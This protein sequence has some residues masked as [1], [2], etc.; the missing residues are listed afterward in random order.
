MLT[1]ARRQCAFMLRHAKLHKYHDV[2]SM[3]AADQELFIC[4]SIIF[5]QFMKGDFV[6]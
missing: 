1:D 5:R 6:Q 3:F 2:D 4:L